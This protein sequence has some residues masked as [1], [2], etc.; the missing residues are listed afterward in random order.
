MKTTRILFSLAL[1]AVL[2]V[3][4]PSC[5]LIRTTEHRIR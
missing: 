3:V 1:I 2:A 4:L 5:L